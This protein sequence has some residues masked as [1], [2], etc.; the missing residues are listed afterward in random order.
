MIQS[1]IITSHPC[2][3]F[4][5]QS[6]WLFSFSF[7]SYLLLKISTEICH[8][9]HLQKCLCFNTIENMNTF[10]LLHFYQK[11][12]HVS[13][14]TWFS[15]LIQ[16]WKT[17][18]FIRNTKGIPYES[19]LYECDNDNL[20]CCTPQASSP[21][22]HYSVP[23]PICLQKKVWHS[24]T[25]AQNHS[26]PHGSIFDLQL[27]TT[28]VILFILQ[29]NKACTSNLHIRKNINWYHSACISNSTKD[30]VSVLKQPKEKHFLRE[31][32]S[33]YIFDWRGWKGFTLFTLL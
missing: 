2:V 6:A 32:S 17:D 11:H 23:V 26:E 14:H 18:W 5:S 31:I 1:V 30:N 33:E 13:I 20:V 3:A 28:A 7:C 29:F 15:S 12:T 10:A 9:M 21:L 19:A 4:H 27:R 24:A 8:Q 16:E 25:E 22:F